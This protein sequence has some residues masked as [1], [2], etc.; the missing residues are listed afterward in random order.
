M[1][2][3]ETS[4][5]LVSYYGVSRKRKSPDASVGLIQKLGK[6]LAPD[7]FSTKNEIFQLLYENRKVAVQNSPEGPFPE[8][9]LNKDM[10]SGL[11]LYLPDCEDSPGLLIA[12]HSA[13]FHYTAEF[14]SVVELLG[15]LVYCYQ[16]GTDG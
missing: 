5:H 1:V 8:I 16:G 12:N 4:S 13:P 6:T 15:Q 9:L 3:Q 10:R 11:A 7:F 14:I 2:A